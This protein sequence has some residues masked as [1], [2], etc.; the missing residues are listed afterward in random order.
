MSTDC[1]RAKAGI[2]EQ[3]EEKERERMLQQEI[4]ALEARDRLKALERL[5]QEDLEV[6]M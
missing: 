6:R 5:H 2:I 4:K 3:M 1:P